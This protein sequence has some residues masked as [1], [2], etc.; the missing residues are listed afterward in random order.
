MKRL[1]KKTF[2]ATLV[3][4]AL[5]TATNSRL[6][7]AQ[8]ASP[9][10]SETQQADSSKAALAQQIADMQ[11]KA[12]RLQGALA[13][14]TSP[15]AKKPPM[16]QMPTASPMADMSPGMSSGGGMGM[17]MMGKG[18]MGEEMMKRMGMTNMPAA[19]PGMA[20][21]QPNVPASL[22][23]D[24]RAYRICIISARRDFLS[25]TRSTSISRRNSKR[26]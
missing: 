22:Y 23:R 17:G 9:T 24:F 7:H 3:A 4:G 12:A 6:L 11:A 14:N 20:P 13:Q 5:F 26:L 2:F 10:S 19:S 8:A 16:A 1:L 21:A 25:I 18:K 15:A